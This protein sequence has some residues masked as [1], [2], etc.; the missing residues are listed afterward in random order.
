MA[1]EVARAPPP[2]VEGVGVLGTRA[3]PDLA[4]TALWESIVVEPHVKEELLGQAVL[5]FVMRPRVDRARLPFHGII[6]L[7][8]PP[9][10]G[11]TSLAR[12]LASRV[13]ESLRLKGARLVEVNP[14]ALTSSALGKSQRAVTELL[15]STIKE[16]ADLGPL[17]VLLDEVETLAA[18]RYKMSTEANPIDVHRAV[19][20]VLAQLDLLAG[21]YP[22]LLFLAT[23]NFEASLD[24][25][26][27]SRADLVV[28]LGLPSKEAARRILQS[29]L[30]ELAKQ[31]PKTKHLVSGKDLDA[32]ADAV[33]G[34]DARKI[35]KLVA[36][37]CAQSIKTAADPNLL[38]VTDLLKAA[39]EA[40]RA[41]EPG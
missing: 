34:L 40:Q 31:W 10:T 4:L 32:V 27:V 18:S 13:A 8:G 33:V 29:S 23:T 16:A 11:K 1:K 35:R 20:A 12:G 38:Q 39:A 25:A 3:L 41:K 30:E 2:G 5:T 19:D 28:R 21:E 24:A 15:G 22:Q 37:A 26:F 36:A 14:H 17:I 7:T 6:L 9:G